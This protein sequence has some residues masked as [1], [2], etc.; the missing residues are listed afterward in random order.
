MDFFTRMDGTMGNLR[1]STIPLPIENAEYRR[2][3]DSQSPRYIMS[4]L[5]VSGSSDDRPQQN[6]ERSTA[7]VDPLANQL[8][9]N[10]TALANRLIIFLEARAKD[11][12]HHF[13]SFQQTFI[14]VL[15]PQQ[16]IN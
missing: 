7:R 10:Q 16:R 13:D 4:N 3:G 2:I 9:Q 14:Q 15:S 11:S 12:R 5:S 8:L 1:D 6:E